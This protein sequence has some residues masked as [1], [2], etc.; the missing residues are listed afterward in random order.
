MGNTQD[1]TLVDSVRDEV[2]ELKTPGQAEI[3]YTPL[4]WTRLGM[5][6]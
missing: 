5:S 4:A 3:K 2:D 6:D 1:A